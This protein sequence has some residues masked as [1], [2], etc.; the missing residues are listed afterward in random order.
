MDYPDGE[1]KTQEQPIPKLGGLAVAAAFSLAT[2]LALL[3]LESP[4]EVELALSALVPA[5]LAGLIGYADDRNHLNPYLRLGLHAL[6]GIVAWQPSCRLWRRLA[7]RLGR[8][9]F[10]HASHQR[11]EPAGQLRRA[12]SQHRPHLSCGRLNHRFDLWP[13]VRLGLGL[14]PGRSQPGLPALQLVPRTGISRG[15]RCLFPRHA[16]GGPHP[17]APPR[18]C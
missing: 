17:S 7:Q 9:F 13:A 3:V 15:L 11:D 12:G 14:C 8:R 1:R 18:R 5:L 6:T 4:G 16:V 10:R 2:V